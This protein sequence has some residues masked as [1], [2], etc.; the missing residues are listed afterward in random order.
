MSSAQCTQTI[1][2]VGLSATMLEYVIG[3][4]NYYTQVV[5]RITIHYTKLL[6]LLT[7]SYYPDRR[8]PRAL[9]YPKSVV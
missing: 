8:D 4:T 2:R 6:S 9:S 1:A 7:S 5:A 3:H